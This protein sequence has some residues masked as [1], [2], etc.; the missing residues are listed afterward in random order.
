MTNLRFAS[1]LFLLSIFFLSLFITSCSNNA[2]QYLL[3]DVEIQESDITISLLTIEIDELYDQFPDHVFGALRPTERSIFNN[4]LSELFATK[5]RSRV[6]GKLSTS[7][8]LEHPF[9]ERVFE[10]NNRSI[11]MIAPEPGTTIRNGDEQTRFVVVLDQFYFTPYQVQ[12]GGDSYAGHEGDTENR[13]RFDTKYLIWDNEKREAIAWG[14]IE[15]NERLNINNQSITYRNLV[16]DAFNRI[17]Q[18]SP[19]SPVS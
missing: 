19:F 12:V 3:E 11:K 17:I 4:Q 9:Q 7:A 10:M 6:K 16:L 13:V 18:Y 5:T 8:L 14:K 15:T 1:P 2:N